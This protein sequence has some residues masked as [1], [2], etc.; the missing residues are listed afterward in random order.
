MFTSF[1]I[2]G[3]MC[4]VSK[5]GA[6]ELREVN[7][8]VLSFLRSP[9]FGFAHFLSFYILNMLFDDVIKILVLNSTGIPILTRSNMI[10]LVFIIIHNIPS[11]S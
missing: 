7:K 5:M 11:E 8:R 6:V 9:L 2:T 10:V 3:S 1:S 4:F